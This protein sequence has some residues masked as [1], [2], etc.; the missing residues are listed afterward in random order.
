VA[1]FFLAGDWVK[2][3]TPAMLMESAFTS[4]LIA[5][6]HLLAQQGLQEEPIHSVPRRGILG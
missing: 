3:H 6:N 5:A 4:G 1:N 2:I